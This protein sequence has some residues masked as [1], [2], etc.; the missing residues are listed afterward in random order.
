MPQ[1]LF[2]RSITAAALQEHTPFPEGTFKPSLRL[3]PGG[4]KGG[5]ARHASSTT[6]AFAL[7]PLTTMV[8]LRL[9][10]GGGDRRVTAR[11]GRQGRAGSLLVR[12]RERDECS[13]AE[14][15]RA[16]L[17]DPGGVGARKGEG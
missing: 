11:R 10:R 3:D 6:A 15:G 2:S 13:S 9:W 7:R 16:N 8:V 1:Q 14:E 5:G 17:L 12:E 4:R